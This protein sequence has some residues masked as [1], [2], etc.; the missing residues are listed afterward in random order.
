[1]G[2]QA[3]TFILIFVGILLIVEGIYLLAFGGSIRANSRLNRRL[4]LLEQGKAH[5]EVLQTLR[6]E[7]EQH[8]KGFKFPLF[9]MLSKKAA[10][11]NVAFSPRALIAVMLLVSAFSGTMLLF[12]TASGPLTA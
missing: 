3:I 9:S 2:L 8:L 10:H 6:K 12:F 1:M 4:A 11:A 5:E 7:R